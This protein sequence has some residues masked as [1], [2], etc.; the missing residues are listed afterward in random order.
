MSKSRQ[1]CLVYLGVNIVNG[2]Q[3]EIRVAAKQLLLSFLSV[4]G[5][6]SLNLDPS[7]NTQLHVET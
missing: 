6:V 3:H 1:F 7:R 2:I 5:H 4:H